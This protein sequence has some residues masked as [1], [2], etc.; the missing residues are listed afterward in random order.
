MRPI[1]LMIPAVL[2]LVPMLSAHNVYG[3]TTSDHS[4]WLEGLRLGA[5]YLIMSAVVATADGKAAMDGEGQIQPAISAVTPT[6][7]LGVLGATDYGITVYAM[8]SAYEVNRQT[9]KKAGSSGAESIDL[10]TAV[11]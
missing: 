3:E 8:A 1:A 4:S 6:W 2:C 11:R 7:K 9:V 5:G 10:G